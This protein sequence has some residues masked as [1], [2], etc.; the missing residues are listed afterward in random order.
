MALRPVTAGGDDA[1]L[2]A[3]VALTRRRTRLRRADVAFRLRS[4]GC[5]IS[6]R[7]RR[8]AD[9]GRTRLAY[10]LARNGAAPLGDLRYLADTKL[11]DAATPMAKA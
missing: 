11:A 7:R 1:W 4:I 10:V 3:Y 2:D 9:G 6:S 8:A 5:A